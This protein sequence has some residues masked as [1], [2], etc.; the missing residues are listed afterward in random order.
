MRGLWLAGMAG[1]LLLAGSAAAQ[2]PRP[3]DPASVA[4]AAVLNANTLAKA[5]AVDARN[6]TAKAAYEADV[7][8]YQEKQAAY[9]ADLA[10]SRAA[11]EAFKREQAAYEAR[12]REWEA[13]VKA[14][15]APGGGRTY[16]PRVVEAVSAPAPHA[17]RKADMSLPPVLFA[18][19]PR[20]ATVQL[21]APNEFVQ[22]DTNYVLCG[23]ELRL[24][25]R[26]RDGYPLDEVQF[27]GEYTLIRGS[28]TTFKAIARRQPEGLRC[29]RQS[30]LVGKKAEFEKHL[31][32]QTF[33]NG[34]EVWSAVDMWRHLMDTLTYVTF[35]APW[36]ES[37]AAREAELQKAEAERLAQRT[38]LLEADRARRAPSPP[39]APLAPQTA[40]APAMPPASTPASSTPGPTDSGPRPDRTAAQARLAELSRQAAAVGARPEPGF[41]DGVYAIDGGGYSINVKGEGDRL[42]V[43]EPN[44]RS[45]YVR[46]PDGT[47]HFWNPNTQ[48]TY[49]L[50]VVNATT[51]EAF[52]PGSGAPGTRL[53]R[54]GGPGAPSVGPD[55]AVAERYAALSRS[56]PDDAQ[57]WTAC[58]A[59]AMKRSVSGRDEA[60]AYGTQVA[61]ML[62]LILVDPS[63]SPC[64]DAIPAALW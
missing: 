25:F 36:P 10:R 54:T 29:D 45:E 43:V 22:L 15:A 59:A 34:D 4:D 55:R 50:R 51:I 6:A 5:E 16:V 38:A 1:S 53:G 39:P 57:T 26:L 48:T 31:L 60:D 20:I 41:N 58:A 8:A 21:P 37:Y 44:K 28:I 61:E 49:G 52:R 47:Y 23:D 63:R 42:I 35:P 24:A 30:V 33:D 64:P 32:Q 7:K 40:S 9:L 46:Q 62:K 12:Q 17:P 3:E 14:A 13:Q 11:D 18:V 19:L 56:D 2:E 27:A